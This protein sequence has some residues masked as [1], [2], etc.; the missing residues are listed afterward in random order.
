M[1]EQLREIL[2]S[3]PDDRRELLEKEIQVEGLVWDLKREIA[4]SRLTHYRL[5]K[6]SGVD[7]SGIDRFMSGERDLTFVSAGKLADA[8]GLMLVSTGKPPETPE[9]APP[10]TPPETPAKASKKS[11]G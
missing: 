10:E 2:S 6:M 1:M 7:I 11:R 3:L 8:L 9:E 4:N 5:A